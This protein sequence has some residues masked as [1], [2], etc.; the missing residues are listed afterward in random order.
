MPSFVFFSRVN[1]TGWVKS[2]IVSSSPN[3]FALL[4]LYS[5]QPI[6]TSI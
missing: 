3:V 6:S 1:N 5:H 2:P 4:F